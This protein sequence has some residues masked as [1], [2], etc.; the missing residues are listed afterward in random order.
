[1]HSLLSPFLALIPGD[2][3]KYAS[4]SS[5]RREEGKKVTKTWAPALPGT[6]GIP[7]GKAEETSIQRPKLHH[8]QLDICLVPVHPSSRKFK[9][10]GGG[11]FGRRKRAV[12]SFFALLFYKDSRDFQNFAKKIVQK[13]LIHSKL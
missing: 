2:R 9:K 10:R 6:E 8:R 4:A 12:A 13:I 1:M 7:R 5:E 11:P 3:E